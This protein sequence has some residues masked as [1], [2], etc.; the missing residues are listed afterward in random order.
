MGEG[1]QNNF[2]ATRAHDAQDQARH[3]IGGRQWP[4]GVGTMMARC[5]CLLVC[6]DRDA[7]LPGGTGGS[8]VSPRVAG[9]MLREARVGKR[10]QPLAQPPERLFCP[11]FPHRR[12]RPGPR[13]WLHPVQHPLQ[14]VR[15]A[16]PSVLPPHPAHALLTCP[17]GSP[18][19]CLHVK[20]S[21]TS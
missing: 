19:A 21:F 16:A 20:V 14:P 3:R 6:R 9:S 18:S 15:W 10:H 8:P 5:L 11:A 2:W 4:S 1:W 12:T 7:S 13:L 17:L